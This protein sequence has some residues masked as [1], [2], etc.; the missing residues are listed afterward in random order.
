[1]RAS[2]DLGHCII[3]WEK[4]LT[5]LTVRLGR[6]CENFTG[7]DPLTALLWPEDCSRITSTELS[8]RVSIDVFLRTHYIL[9]IRYSRLKLVSNKPTPVHG[10]GTRRAPSRLVLCTEELGMILAADLD[11]RVEKTNL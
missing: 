3:Y 5:D 4:V 6:A 2:G 11:L 1:M 10:V 8:F 7:R 9:R